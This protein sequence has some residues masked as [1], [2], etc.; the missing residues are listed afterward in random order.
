ML[1]YVFERNSTMKKILAL[2]LIAVSLLSVVSCKNTGNGN[3]KNSNETLAKFEEY[4]A[5][6]IPTKSETDIT[7]AYPGMEATGNI[8]LVTGTVDGKTATMLTR[9][10]DTLRDLEDLNLRPFKNLAKNLWYLEGQGT[11]DN[12]GRTWD[13]NG[14][15]FAPVEGSISL[16]LKEEYFSEIK[17]NEETN[18]LILNVPAANAK[19]VLS[20]FIDSSTSFE[21]DTVITIVAAGGRIASIKIDYV[22]EEEEFGDI[23]NEVVIEEA[24]MTIKTSYSY[25]IQDISFE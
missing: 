11:S 1:Q 2:I 6:S 25:D 8:V 7:Y 22:I 18:I 16:N 23:G 17:Y 20:K 19:T 13:E 21:Y 9:R 14:K 15:N 3:D 24:K 12:K 5:S 10:V 4:F